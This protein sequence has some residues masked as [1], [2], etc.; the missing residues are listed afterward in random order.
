M[1]LIVIVILLTLGFFFMVVLKD[2]PETL[3]EPF[4]NEQLNSNFIVSFLKTSSACN[5]YTMEDLIQDCAVERRIECE[6]MDSCEYV[7]KTLGIILNNT[8]NL[9]QYD[10]NFTIENV[11]EDISFEQNCP[12]DATEKQM[13]FQPISLYPY[14][15]TVTVKLTLCP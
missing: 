6:N 11:Q 9:W 8:L 2:V 1:G 14:P 3:K 10:Y 4:E 15:G 12:S 5:K 13:G 7:N